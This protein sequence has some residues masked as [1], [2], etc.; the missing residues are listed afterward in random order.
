MVAQSGATLVHAFGDPWVIEGQGTVGIEAAAQLEARIGRGPDRIVACCGGRGL[1]A[2]LS[3]ACP[4]AEIFIAEPEGWDDVLRSLAAGAILPVEDRNFP[5]DC[6]ALQTLETFPINFDVLR[7]RV[8][9]GAFVT[10]AE[11]GA[12]MRLAF[13]KLHLVS[14][15]AARRRWRRCWRARSR[16][17][18]RRLSHSRGAMSTARPSCGCSAAA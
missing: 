13:E 12:A 8:S 16:R 11:I 7:E 5:T 3:L 2:G 17:R 18:T 10:P 9:G 14:S 15:R 6:D 4:D 1:T